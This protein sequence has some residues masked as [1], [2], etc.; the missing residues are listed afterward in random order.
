MKAS[1]P[2]CPTKQKTNT[3]EKHQYLNIVHAD[4]YHCTVA[5]HFNVYMHIC[6]H[7][8]IIINN[9]IVMEL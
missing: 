1:H 2:F 9:I 5:V 6:Y 8:I 3:A 4:L 7:F